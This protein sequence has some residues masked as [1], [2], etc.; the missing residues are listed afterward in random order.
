MIYLDLI[1][2]ISAFILFSK[3]LFIIIAHIVKRFLA[4]HCA[5]MIHSLI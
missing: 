2:N 5:V 1:H 3:I 4:P